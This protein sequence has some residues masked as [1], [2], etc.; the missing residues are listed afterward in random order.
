MQKLS[1]LEMEEVNGGF[2]LIFFSLCAAVHSVMFVAQRDLDITAF[3]TA[4]GISDDLGCA[5]LGF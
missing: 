5:S 3:R 4:A 1:I 2:N